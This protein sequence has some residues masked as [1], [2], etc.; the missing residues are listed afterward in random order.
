MDCLMGENIILDDF[1]MGDGEDDKIG[2]DYAGR[3]DQDGCVGLCK[4]IDEDKMD[5]GINSPKQSSTVSHVEKCPCCNRIRIQYHHPDPLL[6]SS[7]LSSDDERR[8]TLLSPPT[9]P[10]MAR[11]NN[12]SA[13]TPTTISGS[14]TM[15]LTR[16]GWVTRSRSLMTDM[17]MDGDDDTS[18][19]RNEFDAD[20]DET[21]R[22]MPGLLSRG[23]PYT[24]KRVIF[25]G[26]LHKKGSGFDWF[27]S[28][29]WKS[30]WAVLVQAQLGGHDIGL[31]LLEIYWTAAS[32]TPSTVITL[33]SAVI[34][35]E[36][37]S[38]YSVS[39]SLSPSSKSNHHPYRFKIRHI[40]KS[41]NSDDS[42]TYH[43]LTRVFGSC[44]EEER[45]RWLSAINQALFDF[46]KEKASARRRIVLDSSPPR[47]SIRRMSMSATGDIA[48]NALF[49]YHRRNLSTGSDS[50]GSY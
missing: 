49:S 9:S 47:R 45:D 11:M 34:V 28:R 3:D 41:M 12:S 46:E 1:D 18:S 24:I 27:G 43:K 15:S 29:S 37:L 38:D 33:D 31:P 17:M 4:L 13:G 30:R 16:V 22:M 35:P 25:Q 50:I 14:N 32:P 26:Y 42:T 23:T 21:D 40:K 36:N 20:P 10:T 44:E 6:R 39:S 48:P 7:L 5:D 2:E 19:T 8:H